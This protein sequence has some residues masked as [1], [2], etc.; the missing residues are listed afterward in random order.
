[1]IGH[2]GELEPEVYP[3][4]AS[5][6]ELGSLLQKTKCPPIQHVLESNFHPEMKSP[7]HTGIRY[8]LLKRDFI[9]LKHNSLYDFPHE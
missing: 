2:S 8:D 7:R 9:K 5:M 4:I 6:G 3:T 1:M